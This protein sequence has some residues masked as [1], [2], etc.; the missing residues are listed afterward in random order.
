[1]IDA[2]CHVDQIDSPEEIVKEAEARSFTVIA[3]TNLPTHY[4]MSLAPL[5]GCR[6]VKPALGFHPLMVSAHQRELVP[7]LRLAKTANFIGEIGLDFSEKGVPSKE[8]QIASFQTILGALG[9]RQRFITIHSRCAVDTVLDMLNQ[10]RVGPVVFHW[11]TGSTSQMARVITAGHYFSINPAMVR[12]SA[13]MPTIE[14]MPR[15]RVLT[16]TDAPLARVDG[17][18]TF[19]WD[20]DIVLKHLTNVWKQERGELERTIEQNFQRLVGKAIGG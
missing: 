19:P 8:V 4:A 17:R 15:D 9:D 11:F 18:P 14:G 20:I 7:F 12:S 6:Y 13:G 2:H 10:Q 5:K 3:V 16:E 1:M